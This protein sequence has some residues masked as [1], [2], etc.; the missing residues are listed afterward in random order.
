MLSGISPRAVSALLATYISLASETLQRP[1]NIQ[2]DQHHG[3]Q[4]LLLDV[5]QLLN[6][7]LF[8][9]RAIPW[10]AVWAHCS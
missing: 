4:E 5:L 8:F 2:P 1:S 9:Y 7:H 6:I 10:A 3:H